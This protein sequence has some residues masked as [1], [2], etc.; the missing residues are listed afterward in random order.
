MASHRGIFFPFRLYLSGLFSFIQ[1]FCGDTG[2]GDRGGILGEAVIQ[3][4]LVADADHIADLIPV[5]VGIQAVAGQR[6][7][8]VVQLAITAGEAEAVLA[9]A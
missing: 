3:G 6:A 5:I 7:L 4:I 8:L 9:V 1:F 2:L